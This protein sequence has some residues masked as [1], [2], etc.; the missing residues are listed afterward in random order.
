MENGK[1]DNRKRKPSDPD[2]GITF[3]LPIF[4]SDYCENYTT[5]TEPINDIRTRVKYHVTKLRISIKQL[6]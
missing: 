1:S 5:S 4:A 2:F 3:D 6:K